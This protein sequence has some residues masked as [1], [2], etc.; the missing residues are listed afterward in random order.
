ML[1][2]AADNKQKFK[3]LNIIAQWLGFR[4]LFL[5]LKKIIISRWNILIRRHK[6]STVRA[7]TVDYIDW[8][9]FM[10]RF[11]IYAVALNILSKTIVK[12]N[13]ILNI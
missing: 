7:K 6:L 11:K 2:A 1:T 5:D 13:I 10:I 4:F 9:M 12:Y 3:N 8:I